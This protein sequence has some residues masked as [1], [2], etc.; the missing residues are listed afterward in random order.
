VRGDYRRVSLVILP[1]LVGTLVKALAV[2][3]VPQS[4]YAAK[5]SWLVIQGGVARDLM[6]FVGVPKFGI[7]A[8][9]P[10][11]APLSAILLTILLGVVTPVAAQ[12]TRSS[13]AWINF[14][15]PAQPLGGALSGY[16]SATHIQLFVDASLTSGRRSAALHGVFTAEAGLFGLIAGTGLTALPIGDEGFTLIPLQE[17]QAGKGGEELQSDTRLSALEFVDYSARLQRDL[18]AALC[19]RE[20]TRPG[21]YRTLVRLWLGSSGSVTRAD[22]LTSTGD[23]ARDETLL[24]ALRSS[25]AGEAPPRGLPQPITL[26][27]TPGAKPSEDY[28]PSTN[29]TPRRVDVTP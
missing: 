23:R 13:E 8:K 18:T 29:T 24:N 16:A 28:C 27:L 26:L 10:L 5:S 12:D 15:I 9:W 7:S 14:D 25:V 21:S 4:G 22:V 11:I 2:I 19:R 20:D 6:Y 17:M 3:R 1:G